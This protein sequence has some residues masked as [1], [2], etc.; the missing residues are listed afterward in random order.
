[1]D[2]T[3]IFVVAVIIMIFM[4]ICSGVICWRFC[5]KKQDLTDKTLN[6]RKI[7]FIEDEQDTLPEDDNKYYEIL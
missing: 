7:S 3:N 6:T 4:I 2:V 5:F 1:M